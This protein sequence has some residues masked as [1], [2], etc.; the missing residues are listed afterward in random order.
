MKHILNFKELLERMEAISG[1][2]AD[3]LDLQGVADLHDIEVTPELELEFEIGKEV[4]KEHTD[5]P[6]E[7]EEI[8][9]DHLAENPKYYTDLINSGV[10]DE[11]A[12]LALFR[13]RN[14]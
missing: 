7:A 4:E 8:A 1:G 5:S 9:L 10:V 14:L 3:R 2:K 13:S 12:A 11:P 6:Q